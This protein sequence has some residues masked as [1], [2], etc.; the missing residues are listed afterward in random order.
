MKLQLTLDIDT[1]APSTAGRWLRRTLLLGVPVAA[2]AVAGTV[3]GTP[4][5]HFEAMKVVSATQMN[6]NFEQL[7]ARVGAWTPYTCHVVDRLT[8]TVVGGDTS[9][10]LYR[11]VGDSLEVRA[12][13]EWVA[14]PP[15]PGVVVAWELPTMVPSV[16][17]VIVDQAKLP[18]PSSY[19]N[20]LGSGTVSR[21]SAPVAL[22]AVATSVDKLWVVV[23]V[24]GEGDA[25]SSSNIPVGTNVHISFSVP[26]VVSD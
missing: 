10:C 21:P 24:H 25:L 13:S 16:G 4:K 8:G 12:Y 14:S 18:K 1:A 9:T 23:A 7:D 15:T 6:E 17:D 20:T 5:H 3:W 11:R 19:R 2:I 26:I 22:A